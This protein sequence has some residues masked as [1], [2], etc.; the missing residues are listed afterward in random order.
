MNRKLKK[1]PNKS[2]LEKTPPSGPGSKLAPKKISAKA[3]RMI[4]LMDEWLKDESGY[5]EATWPELKKS[6]EKNRLSD[7]RLFS[8]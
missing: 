2:N 3:R 4:R 5:D 1:M 7:R 8:D 6:L